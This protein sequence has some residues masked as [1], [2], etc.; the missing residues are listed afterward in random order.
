[1]SRPVITVVVPGFDVADFAG[2]AVASLEAQE[3]TAWRAVLVDDASGDATGAIFDDAAARDAR[4]TVVR[5]GARRGL[6]AARNTGLE[7]AETP[8]LAFLD[9]DD[10]MTPSALGRW[11]ETL[12]RTGS[13]LVAG[14]YVR[15][16]PTPA[17][18]YAPGPVQPWVARSTAPARERV[19]LREH[20]DVSG[21]IV[22]WSK[23]S[24]TALWRRTGIR[25]PVGMAYEDQVVAQQL[26]T[27]A[28]S[29]DVIPD[30]VVEWRERA[31]GS[32]ITQRKGTLTILRD[33]LDALGGGLDVLDAAGHS[34]AIRSRIDL[35]RQL[36]LPPLIEI[37]RTHPDDAYR[38]HLGAFVRALDERMSVPR[39]TDDARE[40][41][42]DAARLW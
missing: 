1:M 5:H 16:R 10:R 30:V 33:Y 19:T 9:A 34:A 13:D 32:S 4:F 28:R 3:M 27:R 41:A 29:F 39:G 18:G 21:N 37:A 20:P 15:L 14:A 42:L 38:R 11:T 40:R 12:E 8:F 17:G 35:I 2:E 7:L 36:D 31:D 25:F 24:R 22:A 6:G 23:A 26:Y